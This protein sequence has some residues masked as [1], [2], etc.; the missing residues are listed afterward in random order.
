METQDTSTELLKNIKS[1]KK[2][3]QFIAWI[4]IISIA[5]VVIDA[6]LGLNGYYIFSNW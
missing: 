5:I 4:I 6:L 1:I 2:N 3:V